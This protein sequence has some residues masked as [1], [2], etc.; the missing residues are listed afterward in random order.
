MIVTYLGNGYIRL[1]NGDTV[2]GVDPS[3]SRAKNDIALRTSVN[4][5][6]SM[7]ENG[8]VAFSG[9]YELKGIEILGFQHAG[10]SDDETVRTVYVLQWDGLKFVFLGDISLPPDADAMKEIAETDVLFVPAG[11]ANAMDAEVAAK[12]IRQIE[13]AVVIPTYGKNW[14]DLARVM[15]QKPEPQEKFVFKKKDL[16]SKEMKLV[17]VEAK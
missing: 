7:P 1:Q 6:A 3:G 14:Q 4:T 5:D 2:V 8:E 17:V 11:T 12:L 16:V 15:S 13:P 10:E 9:E